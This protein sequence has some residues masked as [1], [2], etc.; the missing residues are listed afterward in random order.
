[1]HTNFSM[2]TRICLGNRHETYIQYSNFVITKL[3]ICT[4]FPC[5]ENMGQF[6]ALKKI[7]S[8]IWTWKKQVPN[9]FSGSQID[10][11]FQNKNS[12][13]KLTGR[14]L[15]KLRWILYFCYLWTDSNVS[16]TEN[17][18]N[19]SNPTFE[20]FFFIFS[21]SNQLQNHRFLHY[22]HTS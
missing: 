3:S 8:K 21:S 12:G 15:K 7:R 22:I 1:M 4:H 16:S 13:C 19:V 11:G 9:F 14:V 10:P 5:F 18:C 2:D 6:V 17:F 20:G